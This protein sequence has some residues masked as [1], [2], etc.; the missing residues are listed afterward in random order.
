MSENML[1]QER[2]LV[3][4]KITHLNFTNHFDYN[5]NINLDNV[6]ILFF[7]SNL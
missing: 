2:Q 7:K 6:V 5:I 4:G 3:I 1:L